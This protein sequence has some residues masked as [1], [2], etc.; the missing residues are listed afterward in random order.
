MIQ[1]SSNDLQLPVHERPS[2]IARPESYERVSS[3][4]NSKRP[5]L[6]A[7]GTTIEAV[8]VAGLA[9][10]FSPI[11]LIVPPPLGRANTGGAGP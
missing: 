9:L 3:G 5:G 6:V 11:P 4:P 8:P 2:A 7:I 1:T 10:N